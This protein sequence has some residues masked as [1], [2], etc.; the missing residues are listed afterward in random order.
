M[1]MRTC[2]RIFANANKA[3]KSNTPLTFICANAHLPSCGFQHLCPPITT[4][5][6]GETGIPKTLDLGQCND[7][8][9]AI[10]VALALADA[11]KCKV[12]DLSSLWLSYG[13]GQANP[14]S[15]ST[16]CKSSVSLPV[17]FHSGGGGRVPPATTPECSPPFLK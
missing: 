12:S 6:I 8:H 4:G 15:A 9:S 7:A 3:Q 16:L 11:L 10:L 1:C 2:A 5:T 14:Q 17:C 13:C